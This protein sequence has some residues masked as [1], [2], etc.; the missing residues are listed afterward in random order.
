MSL[1]YVWQNPYR[2][3]I[4]SDTR[5][6]FYTGPRNETLIFNPIDNGDSNSMPTDAGQYTCQVQVTP[7]N[8]NVNSANYLTSSN[9]LVIEGKY[10]L[11]FSFNFKCVSKI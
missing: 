2:S 1:S 11:F 8:V 6:S 3:T 10:I 9:S 4:H 5:I 7:N